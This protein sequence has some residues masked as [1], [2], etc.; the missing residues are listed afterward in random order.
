M[1]PGRGKRG[2]LVE[3]K[4]GW[5]RILDRDELTQ[6]SARL[7]AAGKPLK[8]VKEESLIAALERARAAAKREKIDPSTI[9]MADLRIHDLRRTLGSWQARTGASLSIIGKSLNHKS[10]QTT[11]IYSRL[12]IDPIRASVERATSAILTAAGVKPE[13]TVKN[14]EQSKHRTNR[15]R[16]LPG[17]AR[18]AD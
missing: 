10:V 5:R 3:P 9:R 2:H 8:P 7:A 14:I 16:R 6:L 1:F 15:S 17:R 4:S 13:A 12:D 18:N 11:A